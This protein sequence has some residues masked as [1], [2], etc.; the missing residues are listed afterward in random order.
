MILRLK[1]LP[2]TI[3][4][5]V[6]VQS[7]TDENISGEP[8]I[9]TWKIQPQVHEYEEYYSFD[10]NGVAYRFRVHDNDEAE[11]VG[12]KGSY[13]ISERSIQLVFDGQG[14][15]Y[16]FILDDDT[17]MIENSNQELMMVRVGEL[18]LAYLPI[19]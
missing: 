4:L 13:A 11:L 1:I 7:C 10:S 17:L 16:D 18:D 2:L 3:F 19:F 9:G 6:V 5:F 12:P 8:I 14:Y 15:F